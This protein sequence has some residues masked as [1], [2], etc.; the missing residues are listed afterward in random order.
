MVVALNVTNHD[1]ILWSRTLVIGI[2]VDIITLIGLVIVLWART[3]LGG[4]W[5][6]DTVL[7]ENHELIQ[8]GPYRYVRH[9]IYSGLLLMALGAA[10]FYGRATGFVAFAIF[11]VT[12]WF[13]AH[14][15]EKLL[16]EQFPE[17][18][19]DYKAR[20]KKFIPFVF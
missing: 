17:T 18:Y 14:Q 13:R 16:T 3:V 10:I 6:T 12:F 1:V 5:S 20:V 19:P 15:E 4:N 11:F 8:V 7:K 2:I 9:P